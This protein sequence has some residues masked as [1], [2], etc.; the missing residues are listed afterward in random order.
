MLEYLCIIITFYIMHSQM[1]VSIMSF[2]RYIW[3]PCESKIFQVNRFYLPILTI[4]HLPADSSC[5]RQFFL[6]NNMR[7]FIILNIILCSLYC[8]KRFQVEKDNSS[9]K[10]FITFYGLSTLYDFHNTSCGFGHLIW[11][12]QM[13]IVY[14]LF[15]DQ[16]R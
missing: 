11:Y 1:H 13:L 14:S 6:N 12:F 16:L 3:I 7:S 4:T 9:N 15:L 10:T 2:V 8:T 5:V